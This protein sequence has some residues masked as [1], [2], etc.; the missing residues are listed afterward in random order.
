M[1]IDNWFKESLKY[2]V[3]IGDILK[4]KHGE[5]KIFHIDR[6]CH[7]LLDD[8]KKGVRKPTDVFKN[9]YYSVIQKPEIKGEPFFTVCK[10]ALNK[11]EDKFKITNWDIDLGHMWCPLKD[12]K[13]PL[14]ID[15]G[16]FDI[17]PNK[18]KSWEELPKNTRIGWRGPC[19]FYEDIN[20]IGNIK[21][22]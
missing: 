5:K 11:G 4:M 15:F 20:K 13:V 14:I 3:T 18:G 12:G 7:D 1:N 17:G 10:G 22:D 9:N 19:I 6:N 16:L 2:H 8:T 21:I